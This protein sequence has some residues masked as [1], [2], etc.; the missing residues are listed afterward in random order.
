VRLSPS[1]TVLTRPD[2]QLPQHYRIAISVRQVVSH[3]TIGQ[4]LPPQ[5]RA[6]ALGRDGRP[7]GLPASEYS[8]P[9]LAA[10][11]W[12]AGGGRGLRV[13]PAG[14]CEILTHGLLGASGYVV[15]HVHAIGGLAGR[16]YLSCADTQLAAEH[17]LG[18]TV[19]ILLDARDPGLRPAAFPGA[20]AVPG[21]PSTFNVPPVSLAKA[22]RQ[23][24][25]LL[26]P[27][28]TARRIGDAWL[29]V[30]ASGTL[31]ARIAILDHVDVCIHLAGPPCPSPS[32]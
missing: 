21:H 27:A 7:I 20:R 5:W 28:I 13:P 12:V 6:V 29:V 23:F 25:S 18:P 1:L 32:G 24:P 17:P 4:L 30:E 31:A 22:H 10:S 16:P 2:P 26:D 11:F 3:S 14:A 9:H 8:E 19:A 15:G